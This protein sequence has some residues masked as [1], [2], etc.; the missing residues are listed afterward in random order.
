MRKNI[1]AVFAIKIIM[2]F[3]KLVLEVQ[4]NHVSS[5]INYTYLVDNF[6]MFYILVFIENNMT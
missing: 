3:I 6:S 4:P 5:V 2:D 1:M